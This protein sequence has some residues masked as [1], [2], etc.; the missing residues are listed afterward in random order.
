MSLMWRS[1]DLGYVLMKYPELLGFKLEGIMSTSIAYL[2]RIGVSPRDIGPV[3]TQYLHLLGM[4]V[5]TMIK[6][7]VD[8]LISIGIVAR[9][10]RETCLYRRDKM[11]TQHYFFSVK[12]KIDPEGFARVVEKM[13]RVV[14]L[15]HDQRFEE[16]L[17]CNFSD[18]DMPSK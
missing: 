4:R 6:P 3:V 7:L 13:P 10:G 9:I 15:R 12:L 2:V 5:G 8:Y 18:A 11:S 14:S 1:K 17:E 16:R